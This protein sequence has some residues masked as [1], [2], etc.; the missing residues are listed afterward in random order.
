MKPQVLIV[1]AGPTGLVLALC[2]AKQ[3]VPF[4]LIDKHTG[5]GEASRAIAVHARTLEL[6][7]QLGLADEVV[8]GGIPVDSVQWRTGKEKK[9]RLP[10]GDLGKGLSPYPF[11]LSY[12]QDDH[13]RLLVDH[14]HRQGLTV[15]WGTELVSF[16]QDPVW[17]ET[18][19]R[20]DGIE[21][22]HTFAYVC[23]C[24]GAHSLVRKGLELSFAGGTYRQ[25]FYVADVEADG[26]GEGALNVYLDDSGF[27][28]FLPVRSTGMVRLIGIVPDEADPSTVT[29]DIIR[30]YV[31]KQTGLTVRRVNWFSTYQ[32]HHRVSEH[33][34]KDR[35]FLAGDAGHI[36]SPAGGQGMN[37]GI[38][39]AVNLAWKLA[40]VLQGKAQPSLLETYEAERLPFARTLV[41]TTDRAFQ[42][43][44]GRKAFNRFM[45]LFFLP[46]LAPLLLRLPFLRRMAFKTVSQTRI[47]YR[48]SGLNRGTAGR[49]QGETACPG[50]ERRAAITTSLCSSAIGSSMFMERP[51][52]RSGTLRVPLPSRSSASIGRLRP[53]PREYRGRPL[54]GPP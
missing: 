16:R 52:R 11:V 38:G 34:R 15:E 47:H 5:P 45:R 32:V 4:R 6:Y 27:C 26:M 31:Y 39:D 36:H 51:R 18:V 48:E 21:E 19:L 30:P 23:G 28:I 14:L 3:G 12:P 33:F 9:V 22:P 42:L 44:V 24:D 8:A 37:T 41:A 29:F 7:R 46:T 10:L 40:A 50:F 49:I 35:V 43:I 17:V 13:E 1:G 54:S 53:E 2:L 20:K 25:V